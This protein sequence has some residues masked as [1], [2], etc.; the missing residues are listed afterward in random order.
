MRQL[1]FDIANNSNFETFVLVIIFLNTLSMTMKWH[2]M[3]TNERI[4]ETINY[5]FTTIFVL[6]AV[7]KLL[8]FGGNY[9]KDSWNVF[10]FFIVTSSVVFIIIKE[11]FNLNL[12]ST[13]QAVR[14]LRL[15][16]ILKLFRSMSKLQIIF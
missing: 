11:L 12:G 15:G 4:M 6:E 10:D 8:A 9:F 5:V 13:T 7:I 16:R 14:T 1:C 2:G 3:S